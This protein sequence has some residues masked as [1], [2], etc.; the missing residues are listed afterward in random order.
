MNLKRAILLG[1][2]GWVLI[3]F[4]VSILM[5]GLK[6]APPA[7]SYYALHYVLAA[8]II[9]AASLLYFR[10][11]KAGAKEGLVL[12]VIFAVVG[13]ILDSIITVPL[14]VKDYS[15]FLRADILIGLLEGIAIATII[16]AVK[17]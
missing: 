1:A 7:A 2:L 8:A 6:L 10:K 9:A 3:F 13:V 17:K 15:F 11:A 12:G 4:E 16:G 14:F 5:F